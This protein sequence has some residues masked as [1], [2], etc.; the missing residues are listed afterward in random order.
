VKKLSKYSISSV[1]ISV[2]VVTIF[3]FMSSGRMF[4]VHEAQAGDIL[5]KMGSVEEDAKNTNVDIKFHGKVVDQHGQPVKGAKISFSATAKNENVISTAIRLGREK[6]PQ[7]VKETREIYSDENGLFQISDL[8]GIYTDVENIE[9]DGYLFHSSKSHRYSKRKPATLKQAS[10]QQPVVFVLWKQGE[11]QA[12]VKVKTRQRFKD[13]EQNEVKTV[14]LV[15][16]PDNPGYVERGDFRIS[17]HNQGRGIDENNRPVRRKY[18]WWVKVEVVDGGMLTTD[19]TWLYEA[20]EEG[21]QKS[22][23]FEKMSGDA[24]WQ[25]G[26]DG[27]NVYFK[28][29]GLFGA[30]HMRVF[31]YPSGDVAVLFNEAF[32]NPTGSRNLEYDPSKQ[33]E[34][35]YQ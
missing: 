35:K 3:F 13:D 28:T 31:A 16:F 14:H 18:D 29:N 27:L 6:T 19:D 4:G 25:N 10:A 32:I 8:R 17:V 20:P 30:A 33:I 1:I 12:L 2:T 9:K 23:R 21:Y 26:L 22:L 34:I 7:H 5:D 15:E 24:N 11:A